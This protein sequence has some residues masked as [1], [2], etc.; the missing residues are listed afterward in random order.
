MH[1]QMSGL[2]VGHQLQTMIYQ[3]LLRATTD[4]TRQTYGAGL[5]RF[6]QFSDRYQIPERARMPA[7]RVLLAAFIADAI[8][9]CSGSCIRNWLNGLRL[10]HLYN[11]AEWHGDEGWLPSL[12]K[13]GERAGVVFKRPPRGPITKRHLHAIRAVLDLSSGF[14]AAAWSNA[15]ACFWGCRRM[16]ELVV[17]SAAKLSTQR[18]T[19]RDTATSFGIVSGLEVI[20]IHLV[21]TKTTSIRG[22]QCILT[23]TIGDD[24]DLCP[25]W[26]FKKHLAVNH[27]P[28]PLT[29]LFAFHE[30]NSWRPLTKD[31]Y[32]RITDTIFKAADLTAVFGHSYRIG[33][34]VELLLA[35]V[36]PEVVMKLGG[37]TSLCFLIY[38]RRLEQIIPARI[39]MAWAARIK[40]FANMH[41][42]SLDTVSLDFGG[43]DL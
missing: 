42:H 18:D 28:P 43:D 25:V 29:P 21:W 5:L 3:G 30:H 9:T 14:G 36:E 41:G 23:Q 37:W 4:E 13:A 33:G 7:D 19:C 27:S 1:D 39:A 12:K 17:K 35:G 22:G 15:T 10:W 16:G 11:D 20:D 2:G 31:H 38:W 32:L 6:H 26:A 34:T 8:G 40:T 24:I